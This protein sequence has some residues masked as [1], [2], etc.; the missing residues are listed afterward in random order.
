MGVSFIY[1]DITTMYK[2]LLVL[3]VVG[4][5]SVQAKGLLDIDA[6]ALMPQQATACEDCPVDVCDKWSGIKLIGCKTVSAAVKTSLDASWKDTTTWASEPDQN[7]KNEFTGFT[8]ALTIYLSAS[9]SSA[10]QNDIK[11]KNIC[12]GF[13]KR[14]VSA[15][16]SFLSSAAASTTNDSACD[17]YPETDCENSAS[18]VKVFTAAPSLLSPPSPCSPKLT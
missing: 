10:C 16:E 18:A 17:L 9:F 2:T 12:R 6:K 14:L 1:L 7:C 15:C 5:A 3:A 13:C 8:C 11:P 4:F